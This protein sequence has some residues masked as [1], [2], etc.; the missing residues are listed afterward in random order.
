MISGQ[1]RGYILCPLLIVLLFNFW[2]FALY[3][4]R[5]CCRVG[6]TL[7]IGWFL[8]LGIIFRFF[9]S[10]PS[11]EFELICG[12]LYSHLCDDFHLLNLLNHHGECVFHLPLGMI[13]Y[14]RLKIQN[15]LFILYMFLVS[16]PFWLYI[17]SKKTTIKNEKHK[18]KK[19]NFETNMQA[20][21]AYFEMILGK[22]VLS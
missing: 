18:S 13:C 12:S 6:F 3:N 20:S 10:H 8:F 22:L 4:C 16:L 2:S 14:S 5:S 7:V 17:C 15:C 11:D 9:Y 1:L 19:R 21:A